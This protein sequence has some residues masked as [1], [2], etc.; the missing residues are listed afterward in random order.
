M[1]NRLN[2]FADD[3][4]GDYD[5]S[6]LVPK[7]NMKRSISPEPMPIIAHLLIGSLVISLMS[8]GIGINRCLPTVE[9]SPPSKASTIAMRVG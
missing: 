2:M 6:N 3:E 4:G 9:S 7:P 5:I 1:K 8:Y